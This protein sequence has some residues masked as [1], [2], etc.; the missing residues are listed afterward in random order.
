MDRRRRTPPCRS[1]RDARSS[2]T[3]AWRPTSSTTTA[4]T[5]RTSPRSRSS[6]TSGAGT[7]CC[8]Y[9]GEYVDIAARAG[10]AVQL[11]TPT[12]RASRRLG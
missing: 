1:S 10:A 12:W 3:A 8:G 11:E 2:P 7:C 9:Y 5:C 4:S 6:T